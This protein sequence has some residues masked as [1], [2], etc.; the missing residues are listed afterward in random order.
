MLGSLSFDS[1]GR[2]T[3]ENVPEGKYRVAVAGIPST[4]Y[5][6]DVLQAGKSVFD[7]GV[8]VKPESNSIQIHI[9]L[10]GPNIIGTVRTAEQHP[11]EYVSV[12]LVPRSE[13]RRNRSLFK[14]VTTDSRG[15]FTISGVTPES[16]TIF[17]VADRPFR[18]P[19]LNA[20]YLS[21]YQERALPITIGPESSKETFIELI[22][23]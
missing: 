1:M 22:V 7:G 6:A 16:Y 21:R 11:A 18:E 17:A 13:R 15:E 3:R 4:G 10:N 12:I 5:I 9:Q 2:L 20:D 14:V 19:W 23:Q 8:V